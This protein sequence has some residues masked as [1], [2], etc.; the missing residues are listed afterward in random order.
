MLVANW[1]KLTIFLISIIILWNLKVVQYRIHKGSQ[2]IPILT[3]INRIPLLT[4]IPPV[5]LL[6]NLRPEL[7]FPVGLLIIIFKSSTTF[8]HSNYMIYYL[9]LLGLI[10]LII[11]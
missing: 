5:I 4:Y 9:N 3:R 2:I 11:R 1:C 7:L 10:T 8:F 6:S